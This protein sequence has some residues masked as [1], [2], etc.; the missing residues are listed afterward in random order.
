MDPTAVPHHL[1]FD[2]SPFTYHNKQVD[3]VI[4]TIRN[5]AGLSNQI[6]NKNKYVQQIVFY[7]NNTPH[8]GLPIYKDGIHMTPTEM[9]FGNPDWEWVY[10]RQKDKELKEVKERLK[11][12]G[13][14][15]YEKY[16]ILMVHLDKGKTQHMF[17]KK[18]RNFEDLAIFNR[19]VNGNV[20]WYLLTGAPEENHMITVPVFYTKKIAKDKT[21]IPDEYKHL[22]GI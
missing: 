17:D 10:I 21:K 14:Y 16:N 18:R 7:Y 22:F 9:Q 12:D 5:A 8:K 19:Y 1:Q 20:E 11:K 2:S 13:Y 4:R 3:S 15:K 6:L